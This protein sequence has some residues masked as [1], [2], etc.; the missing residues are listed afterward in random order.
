MLKT[1]LITKIPLESPVNQCQ[2]FCYDT[3]RNKFVIAT[4]SS[5]N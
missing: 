5:D 2:G 1:Q 4:I 3:K